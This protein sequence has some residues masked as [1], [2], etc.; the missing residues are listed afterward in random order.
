MPR[1]PC[2][3]IGWGGAYEIDGDHRPAHFTWLP[4]GY[5]PSLDM[6]TI[7]VVRIPPDEEHDE[8]SSDHPL[9]VAVRHAIEKYMAE[10]PT[11]YNAS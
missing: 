5:G 1:T 11:V 10:R 3:A 4:K 9:L 6:F 8:W 2:A 7:A